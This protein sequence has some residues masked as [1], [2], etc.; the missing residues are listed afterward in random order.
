MTTPTHAPL[1]PTEVLEQRQAKKQERIDALE[2]LIETSLKEGF[3]LQCMVD[4]DASWNHI[5]FDEV[6]ARYKAAGWAVDVATDFRGNR[7]LTF[8]TSGM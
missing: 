5:I 3:D 6:V 2:T 8:T 4:V 1:T 7:Q